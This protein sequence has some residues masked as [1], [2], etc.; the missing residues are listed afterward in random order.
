[1]VSVNCSK[2]NGSLECN[3]NIDF[4]DHRTKS[5]V[6]EIGTFSFKKICSKLSVSWAYEADLVISP[7][8]EKFKGYDKDSENDT[9]R[10][11]RELFC[12]LLILHAKFEAESIS[13]V[14]YFWPSPGDCFD[15]AKHE[16][17]PMA[18]VVHFT[19]R[20]GVVLTKYTKYGGE[21]YVFLKAEVETIDPV[22]LKVGK[23]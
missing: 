18:G 22:L 6:E 14:E 5:I 19:K 1:M 10:D 16:S 7:L 9:I 4:S 11:Q 3:P 8:M 17:H 12:N 13:G 23:K 2:T 15:K 21:K 20:F